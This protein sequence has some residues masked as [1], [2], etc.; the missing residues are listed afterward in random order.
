MIKYLFFFIFLTSCNSQNKNS[1][2]K[3]YLKSKAEFDTFLVS[4]F[5]QSLSTSSRIITNSK[6]VDKN[7]VGFMLVERNVSEMS[8]DSIVKSLEAKKYTKYL[9]SVECLLVVNSY[10]TIKTYEERT[11]PELL[12]NLRIKQD[13]KEGLL[14]IP[15]F[16]EY[17]IASSLEFNKENYLKDFEIYILESKS[18]NHFKEFNLKPNAQMPVNWQNGYSKGFAVDKLNKTVIYWGIIW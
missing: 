2:E 10:E 1:D 6:N 5:P 11:E 7:D 8:F 16:I 17:N 9:S 18:G 4:H 3:Y 14:P 13:C 12:E 15:N